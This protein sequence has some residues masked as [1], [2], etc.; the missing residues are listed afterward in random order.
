MTVTR[1]RRRRDPL[2]AAV[3]R[4]PGALTHAVSLLR[5]WADELAAALAG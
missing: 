1:S 2:R 5:T 4:D 3:A